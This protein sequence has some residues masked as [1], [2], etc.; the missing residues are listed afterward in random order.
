MVDN[1]EVRVISGAVQYLDADGVD[2]R[3]PQDF[4]RAAV[5]KEYTSLSAFLNAGRAAKQAIIDELASRRVLSRSWRSNPAAN[6]TRLT[7][8]AISP[9]TSCSPYPPRT[10]GEGEKAPI[11]SVS[12]PTKARV[13]LERCWEKYADAGL[14]S[15]ESLEILNCRSLTTFG[16]PVEIVSLFGSGTNSLLPSVNWKPSSISKPL[17]KESGK[18][19]N[20]WPTYRISS[21]SIRDIMRKGRRHLRR[22]SGWKQL[23]WMFLSQDL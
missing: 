17:E 16:T 22:R 21:K 2:D 7:S 18:Q 4:T 13:V 20:Q 3:I 10:C 15:V 8:S 5:R 14:R 1:V 11:P 23:G 9:L 6:S 12:M 19:R